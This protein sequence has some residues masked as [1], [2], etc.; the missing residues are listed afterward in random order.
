MS[1]LSNG[2]PPKSCCSEASKA[3]EGC[4]SGGPDATAAAAGGGVAGGVKP[5]FKEFLKEA[6]R[7]GE[8]DAVT[9]QALAIA[10]SVIQRCDPCVKM[11]IRKARE[12]GFSQEAID[13]AAWMAIAFGGSPIM[14]FYEG[15]RETR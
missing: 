12:M 10:L 5:K 14:M 13:E 4:C 3:T 8:L 6:N 11:H 9:K 7:P 1:E 2:A 15:V